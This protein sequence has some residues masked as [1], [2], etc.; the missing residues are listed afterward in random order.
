MLDMA[1]VDLGSHYLKLVPRISSSSSSFNNSTSPGAID[2]GS[3]SMFSSSDSFSLLLS[4]SSSLCFFDGLFLFFCFFGF[5]SFG[6]FYRIRFS[7]ISSDRFSYS[8]PLSFFNF[9]FFFFS[10]IHCCL[11]IKNF[12]N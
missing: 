6:C 11:F 2:L 5:I 1:S 7:E 9:C 8:L 4:G 10:A 12:I 3:E